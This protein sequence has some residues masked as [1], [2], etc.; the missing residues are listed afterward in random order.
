GRC[1]DAGRQSNGSIGTGSCTGAVPAPGTC[2]GAR[3]VDSEDRDAASA[4]PGRHA[5]PCVISRNQLVELEAVTVE[6]VAHAVSTDPFQRHRF[7]TMGVSVELLVETDDDA[8]EAFAAVEREFRL[9]DAIFSRFDSSS[10]LSRLNRDGTLRCSPEL[11]EVVEL[12]VEARASTGGRFDPTVHDA[13]V[14]AGYDRTF[15]DIAPDSHGW[16]PRA[17]P[18]GGEIS[19]DTETGVV[20]LGPGARIDLGGIVKG[21][22]AER[23]C[24]LLD[25]LGPCLV[26]AAGDLAVRDVPATGSWTVRVDTPADPVVLALLHGGLA[27]SGRDYRRWRRNGM[28]LH[29]LIDP[30][31][32]LPSAT[33]L[34]TVTVVGDDA[35]QAEITAKALFLA[36]EAAAIHEA[37]RRRVPCLLVTSDARVVM[38]GGLS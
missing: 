26:N 17:R 36:G 12:A 34:L 25:E 11:V 8:G 15:L 2:A 35:V 3:A 21:Y 37:D 18:G 1:R 27:T 9:L 28:E 6:A 10:E 16:A 22:A 24:D 29:H 31:T 14:E 38:A 23:A 4:G 32:G 5:S 20:S 13:L 33:D 7:S 30:T 19:I